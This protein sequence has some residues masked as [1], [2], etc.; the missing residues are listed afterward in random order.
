M[1]TA[2]SKPLTEKQEKFC[3]EFIKTGNATEAYK[4]SYSTKNT[5]DKTINENAC[6]LKKDSKIA[7]RI[8]Q[9]QSEVK[10]VFEISVEEKKKILQK[11]IEESFKAHY[12]AQGN[13]KPLDVKAA[14]AAV[15][16]LNR[17]DGDHAAIKTDNKY[18]LDGWSDEEISARLASLLK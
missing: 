9:L 12:D 7:A 8:E 16:E 4:L 17:M 15:S 11:V 13:A 10:K 5:S 2:K 1:T 18:S 6:R 14:I 3:R